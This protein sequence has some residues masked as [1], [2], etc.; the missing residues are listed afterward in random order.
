MRDHPITELVID[1]L[2][3]KCSMQHIRA[4]SIECYL[5]GQ[6]KILK[7]RDGDTEVNYINLVPK[8]LSEQMLA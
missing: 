4:E 7:C 8:I 1:C 5:P 6:Y 3:Y 2:F